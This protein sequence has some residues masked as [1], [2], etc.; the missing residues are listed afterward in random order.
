[1]KKGVVLAV[2]LLLAVPA[3]LALGTASSV[4]QCRT[5][6]DCYQL[7]KTSQ[8]TCEAGYVKS[9][10]PECK[11]NQCEFCRPASYRIVVECRADSECAAKNKCNA[12]LYPTCLGRK[13]ICSSQVKPECNTNNDCTRKFLGR[14]VQKLVCQRNKC[15]TPVAKVILLP[16]YAKPLNYSSAMPKA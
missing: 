8:P 5:R 7:L 9:Y 13:C 10:A 16:W 2:L 4:S 11:N 3:V 12:G 14:P 15:V 6:I 1:M